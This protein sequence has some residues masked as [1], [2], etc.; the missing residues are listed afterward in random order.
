MKGY[1]FAGQL[2]IV[3][4]FKGIKAVTT[5]RNKKFLSSSVG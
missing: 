4:G 5:I 2:R 3:A 1:S